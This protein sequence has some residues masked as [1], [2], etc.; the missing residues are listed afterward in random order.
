MVETHKIRKIHN[1]R[2]YLYNQLYSN[3]F[4]SSFYYILLY[5]YY[6]VSFLMLMIKCTNVHFQKVPCQK[7]FWLLVIKEL[8]IQY[9]RT[10][11]APCPGLFIQPTLEDWF[12][13]WISVNS[14]V[15]LYWII[16]GFPP[17]TKFILITMLWA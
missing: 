9:L 14:I 10:V 2:Q 11:Q 17:V 13:N 4:V 1:G 6:I 7:Y 12:Q 8:V 16:I 3:V 15:S 5:I